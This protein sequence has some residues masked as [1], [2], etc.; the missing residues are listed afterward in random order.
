MT[1]QKRKCIVEHRDKLIERLL[2]ILDALPKEHKA[3]LKIKRL[4]RRDMFRTEIILDVR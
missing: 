3:R 1:T 4:Q 2:S